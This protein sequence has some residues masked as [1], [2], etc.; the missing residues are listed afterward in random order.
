M[1]YISCSLPT[2]PARE[3]MWDI[4]AKETRPIVVYGMG[5]GADKILQVCEERGITVAD[6]FASDGFVRG[7]SFHGKK[8][9]TWSETKEKYE[10]YL[11]EHL[12]EVLLAHM[13]NGE[14]FRWVAG[15]YGEAKMDGVYCLSEA[16]MDRLIEESSKRKMAEASGVL[17][18][19][20]RRLYPAKKKKFAFDF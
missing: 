9:L 13:H 4:L 11:M 19:L 14:N 1:R 3:D 7:H 18:D 15:N 10:E 8:V 16:D 20:K 6:T 2:Y 17:L 5:N 12:G